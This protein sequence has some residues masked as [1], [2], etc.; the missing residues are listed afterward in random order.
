MPNGRSGG[1]ILEKTELKNLVG[2]FPSATL[3]ATKVEFTRLRPLDTLE[4]G[5]LIDEC[6]NDRIAVEEQDHTG[7]I[8]HLS[9][10]PEIIWFGVVPDSCGTAPTA[11]ALGN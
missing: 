4:A 5:R 8:V 3:V 10:E 7:Y 11:P 9:N 2:A 1:F 6:R